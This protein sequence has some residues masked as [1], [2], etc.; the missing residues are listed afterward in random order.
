MKKIAAGF[1]TLQVIALSGCTVKDVLPQG[2]TG[3][4][5]LMI[6]IWIFI[7]ITMAYLAYTRG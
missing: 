4:D 2:Y 3:I 6:I 1:A 7:M 5:Y